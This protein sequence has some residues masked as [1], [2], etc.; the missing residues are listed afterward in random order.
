MFPMRSGPIPSGFT[1]PRCSTCGS[2]RLAKRQRTEHG[3][4][5]KTCWKHPPSLDISNIYGTIYNFG[6]FWKILFI[7]IHE[8]TRGSRWMSLPH[9]SLHHRVRVPWPTKIALERMNSDGR[10]GNC[11][12]K[13][14]MDWFKGKSTEKPWV[15]TIQILSLRSSDHFKMFWNVS[16]QSDVALPRCDMVFFK[17]RHPFAHVQDHICTSLFQ[18]C[19]KLLRRPH[20]HGLESRKRFGVVTITQPSVLPTISI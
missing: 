13:P 20:R 3:L 8:I 14:S 5:W 11:G 19:G 17:A 16:S 2:C 9:R 18:G 6:H 7:I 4:G 1:V 12:F 10:E 15:F